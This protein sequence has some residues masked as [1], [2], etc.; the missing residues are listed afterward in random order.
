MTT[1]Q[2]RRAPAGSS[3]R[4]SSGSRSA[5]ASEDR[6]AAP[7]L[8]PTEEHPLGDVRGQVRAGIATWL[9]SPALDFY[10]LLVIGAL[11]I[12]TGLVMVLSSST[13]ISIAKGGSPFAGLFRQGGFALIGFPLLIIAALIK[14]HVYRRLAWPLL[15]IGLLLQLL[16]FT[17]LGIGAGGNQNWIRVGP[18]TLQ[19]SEAL[20]LALAVWLGAVLATKHK[21]LGQTKQLLL[22]VAPVAVLSIGLVLLGHDLGTAMVMVM[23]VSGSLWVAGVPRRWFA[24]L[25]LVAALGVTAMVVSS[26]NR[27]ARIGNWIHG[28][29]AGSSC[30]QS[31]HGLMALAEGGWTGVGLGESRQ[32]WGLLPAADN[33]YIFAILGEELGLL[34]TLGVLVLFALLALVLFRMITRVDDLFVQ[35]TVAG[36]SAWLLGQAFTN[37]M[38][39]TGLLPVLG[40]PLPFISAGGSAL[41][42][43]MLA[44]GI[45]L[46]FARHE[47]GAADAVRARIG[48]VRRGATVVPAA[49]DATPAPRSR[50]RARASAA[51]ARRASSGSTSTRSA[52]RAASSRSSRTRPGRTGRSSR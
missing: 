12:G 1:Q 49:A 21:L 3:R 16:V 38:V 42:T 7:V 29:C 33:D 10:A 31:R 8:R 2:T 17:P 52:G 5:D 9:R 35:I 41:V 44:L 50:R 26:P 48:R 39:V 6:R 19:P 32:K 37:M 27:M 47:P 23:L 20:K 25:G 24:S 11:L 15:G 4:A 46:S 30:D 40:V 45:L 22:P 43:S 14:P 18:M 51:K 13:V 36:I 34:G 28:E